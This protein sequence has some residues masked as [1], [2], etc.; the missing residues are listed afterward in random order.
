[1]YIFFIALILIA[2]L[3]IIFAVLA[4]N[5]KGGMAANFGASNQVM[6]V[7]QTADFLERFTWILA[8]SIVI[9]SLLATMTMPSSRIQR[10]KDELEK[11]IEESPVGNQEL[12]PNQVQLPASTSTPAS[13]ATPAPT[14]TPAE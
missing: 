6:G 14:T 7:R 13:T 4:Q 12:F 1:M 9:F 2:S 8:I 11:A 3:L 5:P 10:S